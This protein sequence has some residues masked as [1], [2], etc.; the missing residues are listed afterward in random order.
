MRKVITV[1]F[2]MGQYLSRPCLLVEIERYCSDTIEYAV[3]TMQGWRVSQEDAHIGLIGLVNEKEQVNYNDTSLF[4]VFDGKVQLP[5]P[6]V[7]LNQL[8]RLH[9][10]IMYLHCICTILCIHCV[11]VTVGKM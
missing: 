3:G 7:S 9:I 11:Q 2:N 4:A 6:V 5:C 10:H 8:L 1:N